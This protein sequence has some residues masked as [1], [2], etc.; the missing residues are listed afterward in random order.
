VQADGALEEWLIAHRAGFDVKISD[1]YSRVLQLQ[2]PNS[3]KIMSDAT[4]GAIDE[5]MKY[6]HSGFFDIGGQTLY[7]S[8]TGWTGELGYEIY[9][10][11]SETDY[12]KLWDHLFESG[13]KHGM[14]FG[15]L[16]AMGTRRIEAGIMD[17]ISDFDTSMTPFEVGLGAFVELDKE[18]FIGREALLH[19]DKKA[20]MYGLK[21]PTHRPQYQAE[22]WDGKEQ[23]GHVTASAWSPHFDC[24]IGYA[25]FNKAGDWLGKTLLMTVD[26]NQLVSCEI[27]AL[28]FYDVEKIIPRRP[29]L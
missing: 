24:G 2:G 19:A 14:I 28:P 4:N 23:V 6:F 21:C 26:D 7:V 16:D 27:V 22:L 15:S 3:I 20:L 29:R 8:R 13:S 5:S 11:G 12:K 18:G 9:S 17:N 25:R 1:P 10:Q